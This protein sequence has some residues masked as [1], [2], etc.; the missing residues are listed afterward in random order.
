MK[1][2]WRRE[3]KWNLIERRQPGSAEGR[4]E[5]G[6]HHFLKRNGMFPWR[7]HHAPSAGKEKQ[8][9]S[10]QPILPFWIGELM[11]CCLSF[12]LACRGMPAL[13]PHSQTQTLLHWLLH[14]IKTSLIP[15]FNQFKEEF[16]LFILFLPFNSTQ[17]NQLLIHLVSL[18]CLIEWLDLLFGL[19]RSSLRSIGWPTSP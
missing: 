2:S 1:R 17:I 14:F 4:R 5:R 10:I 16:C 8:F 19:V 12:P 15:F 11:D 6:P 9:Q 18:N 3:I 13:V 7:S